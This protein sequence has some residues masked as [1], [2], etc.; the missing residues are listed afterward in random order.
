MWRVIG[1]SSGLW[2]LVMGGLGATAAGVD[3]LPSD[4]GP[5]Q[6]TSVVINEVQYDPPP[7]GNET[8]YE[9]VE[10]LNTGGAPVPLAGWQIAD[11]FTS[12]A[13]PDLT[14][15]PGAFAVLAAGDGFAELF[16]DFQ[17]T[18]VA[19]GGS[20]G[21]GLGNSGDQVRLLD[22]GGRVVDGLSYGDDIALFNPPAP[23]VAAGHSLERVPAGVDTDTAGDWLDQPA[24]SPGAA[25]GNTRP[26][27]APTAAP[28]PTLPPGATVVL[29]EHLPA[30]RS[31]DWD[32]DGQATR[33]DEWVELFNPGNVTI[34]LRGWQLDD[35]ADGGSAP[36]T[37]PAAAVIAPGGHLVVFKRE[38]NLSLN[39]DTDSVRLLRPDGAVADAHAYSNA[40]PDQSFA[41]QADGVGPW[42]D[43]L[44]PSPGGPNGGSV[45]PPPGPSATTGARPTATGGPVGTRTVPTAPTTPTAGAT[46]GP[47]TPPGSG[48]PTAP[49]SATPAAPT[50]Y[51]PLLITEVMFDPAPGGNDAAHEWVEL[52]NRG[53]EAVSLAGWALGDR[54]RWDVLPAA[55]VPPRDF[56]V[57]AS[58]ASAGALGAGGARVIAAPGGR[59]GNGL[60]NRGDVVRLRGPTGA[61]ADAVSFGANLDAF[62]PAVPM[63]P[64]GASI[65]RLPPDADTDSAADWW[66]QPAPSPGRA[67]ARHEGAPRVVL[68]EVLPAPGRVDWDGDGAA[69]HT[70]EWVELYN[71]AGYAVDLGGWR[72]EDREADG[73]EHEL[74]EGARIP[75]AGFLVVYRAASGI[76]LDNEA[77]TLRLIRPDGVIAD[78]FAWARGAGYDRSWSRTVDGAGEWT[79]E[80]TVTPGGPNAPRPPRPAAGDDAAGDEGR[81][82]RSDAADP[83][84]RAA[85]LA[86]L[87]TLKAGTRVHVRGRVTAPP[88][89][90]GERALYIGDETAGVQIY[91]D[92]KGAALQALDEGTRVLVIGRLKDYHGEREIV[93]T[94]MD[95]LRAEGPGPR[96]A[97][98]DVATGALGEG[99]E[100]RLVRLRG[101]VVTA[102]G[103][104]VTLDDGSG[105][106]RVVVLRATGIRRPWFDRGAWLAVVGIAGQYARRAPWADGY[107]LLPRYARDFGRGAGDS[108]EGERGPGA[109][110]RTLPGRFPATG[111]GGARRPRH[112]GVGRAGVG[113][114]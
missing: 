76:A 60:A 83:P 10:I 23:D 20:I 84:A 36:F 43:T 71:A 33:D 99:V 106:A 104:T 102:G 47:G 6:G 101:R 2:A 3:A 15:A 79:A 95:D 65:E 80:Y 96:L 38:S 68:N 53:D 56:I 1:R 11:N 73:W 40:K 77:D 58:S 62:D 70:D 93:V 18:V 52:Y 51:L 103:P 91:L 48:T 24:P 5:T 64:P 34:E 8:A 41:R 92:E 75:P 54:A 12:D 82:G 31:V 28:P 13:I 55:V 81:E 78:R 9:W 37:F 113:C 66:V 86:D 90:L 89:V 26:T 17:G 109:R 19:I 16:P 32:G 112:G 72:L 97:P 87:R 85:A 108:G 27:D 57:V 35:V 4:R 25:A 45:T 30:P 22:P 50:L 74:P 98:V 59:I 107:R 105:P 39:N 67:G 114:A 88:G 29:N 7:S 14:L 49:G 100:G 44:V 63:G 69:G 94:R 21:N 42:T 46:A 61:P 110:G 111:L